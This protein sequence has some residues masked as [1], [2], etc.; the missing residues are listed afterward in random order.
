MY[1]Y[2]LSETA[3]DDSFTDEELMSINFLNTIA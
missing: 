3:T 1:G 2:K